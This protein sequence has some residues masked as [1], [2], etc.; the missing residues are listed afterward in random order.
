[1]RH[2]RAEHDPMKWSAN[3]MAFAKAT[4]RS[5]QPRHLETPASFPLELQGTTPIGEP[6]LDEF[7]G[8]RF[9]L[10]LRAT[11]LQGRRRCLLRWLVEE[12]PCLGQ[13]RA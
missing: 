11:P 7:Q 3:A 1:M 5:V 12:A 13:W 2:Q 10:L 4:D 8:S 9:V 6:C